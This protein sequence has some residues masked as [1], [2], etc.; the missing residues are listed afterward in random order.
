MK[1]AYYFLPSELSCAFTRRFGKS[2][3]GLGGTL[4][5]NSSSSKLSIGFNNKLTKFLGFTKTKKASRNPPNYAILD[6][7]FFSNLILADN[8]I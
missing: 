3:L 1:V 6:S 7:C 8:L 4:F 5:L 2:F